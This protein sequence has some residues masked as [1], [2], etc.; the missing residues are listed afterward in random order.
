MPAP[1]RSRAPF[2]Y[3]TQA[4]RPWNGSGP[5][6]TANSTVGMQYRASLIT[7]REFTNTYAQPN[8]TVEGKLSDYVSIADSGNRITHHFCPE[9]GSRLTGGEGPGSTGIGV[10][11]AS[12]DD[13]SGFKASADLWVSDAQPW[14]LMDPSTP[15]VEKLPS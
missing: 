2:T 10:T 6:P 1:K 8:P 9:C 14:D 3:A 4:V 5:K 12:L 15:K 11:A 7:G 13:P